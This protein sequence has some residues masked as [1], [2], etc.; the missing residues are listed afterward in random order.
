MSAIH[1]N[2]EAAEDF[3]AQ[4]RSRREALAERLSDERA[5]YETVF[6]AWKDARADAVRE[7]LDALRR[8]V[9]KSASDLDDLI[10]AVQRQIDTAREYLSNSDV[11]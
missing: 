4:A 5:L 10:A 6:D 3:C 9:E 2:I 11:W 8:D 1:F 7:R